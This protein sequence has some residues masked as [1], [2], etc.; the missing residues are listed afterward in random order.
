ME[1]CSSRRSMW[2]LAFSM[3]IL[4]NGKS[5]MIWIASLDLK[6]SQFKN[7]ERGRIKIRPR[8]IGD[9]VAVTRVAQRWFIRQSWRQTA[10]VNLVPSDCHRQD[11]LLPTRSWEAKCFPFRRTLNL[12]F[13]ARNWWSSERAPVCQVIFVNFAGSTKIDSF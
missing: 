8:M 12:K 11:S 1:H 6:N 5:K 3:K 7:L 4:S 9:L 10:I 13:K 2:L